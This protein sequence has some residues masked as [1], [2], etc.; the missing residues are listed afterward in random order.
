MKN[1]R[2][3][4]SNINK[5][6]NSSDRLKLDYI[7]ANYYITDVNANVKSCKITA[8]SIEKIN[9]KRILKERFEMLYDHEWLI[10]SSL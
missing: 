2:N 6:N 1:I 5:I 10:N 3:K 8:R 4:F 9:V 7:R